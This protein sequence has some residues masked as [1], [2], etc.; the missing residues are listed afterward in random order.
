MRGFTSLVSLIFGTLETLVRTPI[1]KRKNQAYILI[2]S[3]SSSDCRSNKEVQLAHEDS[4]QHEYPVTFPVSKSLHEENPTEVMLQQETHLDLVMV[5]QSNLISVSA[6][7]TGH[8]PDLGCYVDLHTVI[9]IALCA[10][11]FI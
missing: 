3:L 1:T 9:Y 5:S 10:L 7:E 4:N 2:R 6:F 8:V 11:P